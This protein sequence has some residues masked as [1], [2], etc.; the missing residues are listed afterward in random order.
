MEKKWKCLVTGEAIDITECHDC[1][2]W[3][4]A[5]NTGYVEGP[6]RIEEPSTEEP[7]TEENL[8]K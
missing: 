2:T 1:H 6:D 5:V 7:T 4:C 3:S 8:D